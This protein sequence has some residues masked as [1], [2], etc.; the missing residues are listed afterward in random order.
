MEWRPSGKGDFKT[1]LYFFCPACFDVAN[2][3]TIF[4]EVIA[5]RLQEVLWRYS[6]LSKIA[7]QTMGAFVTIVTVIEDDNLAT[8]AAQ[9]KCCAQASRPTTDYY[10]IV[11]RHMLPR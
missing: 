10:T 4:G 1:I 5:S 6:V 9:H 7:M 3:D 2:D 8:C 11:F